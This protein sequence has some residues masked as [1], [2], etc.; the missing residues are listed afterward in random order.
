MAVVTEGSGL[1]AMRIPIHPPPERGSLVLQAAI[2]SPRP[3]ELKEDI[4]LAGKHYGDKPSRI[5][6]AGEKCLATQTD[7]LL[8]VLKL[9]FQTFPS[10][11]RVSAYGE[12]ELLLDKGMDGLKSLREAGLKK[13]YLRLETGDDELRSVHGYVASVEMVRAAEMARDAGIELSVSVR[14]G[15]GGEGRWRRNVELT[16]KV[17]NMMRPPETRLHHL[18]I[19]HGSLL[20]EKVMRGEFREASR[21]EVLKEMR[22]L[23]SLLNYETRLHVHRLM[24]S[25]LPV[26]RKLPE[27]KERIL[28]ILSFALYYFFGEA[29]DS[30]IVQKYNMSD[31][32]EWDGQ[33]DVTLRH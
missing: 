5:F 24:V 16:A 20:Q 30:E 8:E 21:Y 22:E 6:L 10:L 18:I 13:I 12:V 25:G 2:D 26:E 9:C 17:L 23:V 7:K 19:Q 27:E 4:L 33:G 1:D 32:L 15:V 31:I 29:V 14:L 11:D 28:G 3:E